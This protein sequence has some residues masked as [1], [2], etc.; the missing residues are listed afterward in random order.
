MIAASG[1]SLAAPTP[2]RTPAAGSERASP[3]EPRRIIAPYLC[4]F[5]L[6][7]RAFRLK[8]EAAVQS[9]SYVSG[10]AMR[11]WAFVAFAAISITVSGAAQAPAPPAPAQA[12]P[13]G[14]RQGGPGP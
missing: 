1:C 5:R 12:P 8:A 9:G 6:E 2:P 13:A 14:P 10:G 3:L 4:A 11:V 7:A